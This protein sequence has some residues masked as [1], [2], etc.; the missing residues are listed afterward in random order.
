MTN[1]PAAARRGAAAILDGARGERPAGARPA[2][3]ALPAWPPVPAGR[4]AVVN[5]WRCG[6]CENAPGTG[7]R[8]GDRVALSVR[9]GCLRLREPADMR[10]C[11]RGMPADWGDMRGEM[12]AQT[13]VATSTFIGSADQDKRADGAALPAQTAGTASHQITTTSG[14]KR[15]HRPAGFR[16]TYVQHGAALH[17]ELYIP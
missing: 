10:G 14:I 8:R 4:P 9:G 17:T 11:K 16:H 7:A 3:R 6:P 12:R 2:A 1:D 15:V 13:A 5:A